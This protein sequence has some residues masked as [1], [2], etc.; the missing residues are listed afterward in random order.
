MVSSRNLIV[1]MQIFIWCPAD[2]YLLF[3]RYLFGVLQIIDA[4]PRVI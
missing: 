4:G 3:C 1:V 2:I